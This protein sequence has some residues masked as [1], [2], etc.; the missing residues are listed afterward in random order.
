MNDML[1]SAFEDDEIKKR[2]EQMNESDSL[3]ERRQIACVDV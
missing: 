1:D 3:S 2:T